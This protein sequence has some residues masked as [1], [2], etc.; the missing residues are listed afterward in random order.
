MLSRY[1]I[2]ISF[3]DREVLRIKA[4]AG[5]LSPSAVSLFGWE[6]IEGSQQTGRSGLTA[7]LFLSSFLI[8]PGLH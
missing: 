4:P 6:G 1:K 7:F 3:V 2:E 5:L 8:S